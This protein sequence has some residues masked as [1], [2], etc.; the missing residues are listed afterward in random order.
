MRK[1]FYFH[2]M[3]K[4]RLLC[5]ALLLTGFA[6]GQSSIR[7]LIRTSLGDI[8]VELYPDKAPLTV[9]NF[10]KYVDTHLYDDTHFFRTVRLDNQPDNAVKIEVIQGGDVLPVHELPP[11]QHETTRQSGILHKD[12]TIS[13]A[14]TNDPDSATSQFFLNLVNNSDKLDPSAAP[15][16]YAVFGKI[17]KGLDVLDK[18]AQVPTHSVGAYDDVPAKP[19]VL[20]SATVK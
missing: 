8:T 17:I 16:G 14:R 4:L 2:R 15:N 13:M 6:I 3:K 18:M 7:C 1:V 10:M 19:V 9:M 5:F 12:G 20:I 11:V